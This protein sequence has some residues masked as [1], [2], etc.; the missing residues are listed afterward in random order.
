MTELTTAAGF[1]V[2][3]TNDNVKA[4]RLSVNRWTKKGDR[5]YL[6]DLAGYDDM[7][8]DLETATVEN[9][10][11]SRHNADVTVEGDTMTVTFEWVESTPRMSDRTPDRKEYAV[12]IAIDWGEDAADDTEETDTDADAELV[13]DGGE[14]VM[15]AAD[16]TI[17]DALE[18]HEDTEHPDAYSVDDIRKALGAI[19]SDIVDHWDQYNDEIDDGAY[20]IIHEDRK[21]IVLA[22]H[23]GHFWN[24]QLEVTP[25][26]DPDEYGI[27]QK[28]ILT[29]HHNLAQDIVTYSW[30]TAAPV[31]IYKRDRWEQGE[32]HALCEIARR[33][34]ETGSV[35]RAVDQYATK[36]HGWSKSQW[37]EQTGRNPSTVTRMT[38]PKND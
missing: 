32:L 7:Y 36:V 28:V 25:E 23:T 19:N 16:S 34:K 24:E 5:L 26:V 1:E 27:L 37:A 20:E 8:V 12:E 13:A 14:E 21:K 33:T 22:D 30:S 10:P 35:A 17:Q 11:S 18:A 6:N 9:V 31:V 2:E 38:Q 29:V 4:D 15:V 3:S